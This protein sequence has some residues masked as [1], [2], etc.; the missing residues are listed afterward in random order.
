MLPWSKYKKS[1]FRIFDHGSELKKVKFY[2]HG[3]NIKIK[4]LD[5]LTMVTN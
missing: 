4:V 1:N 3:Q 2:Y 5:F